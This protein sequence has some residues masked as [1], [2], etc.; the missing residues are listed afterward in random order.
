MLKD[1]REWDDKTGLAGDLRIGEELNVI[2]E[3]VGEAMHDLVEHV[4][5]V[6]VENT[7]TDEWHNSLVERV[8][9]LESRHDNELIAVR[10]VVSQLTDKVAL[11]E[12]RDHAPL[13]DINRG[14][15]TF[16]LHAISEVVRDHVSKDSTIFLCWYDAESRTLEFTFDGTPAGGPKRM[17]A[18]SF[19][20][21]GV[22]AAIKDTLTTHG[23]ID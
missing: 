11:I 20:T 19:T 22:I 6:S 12:S 21:D 1:A 14:Q 2:A 8:S 10:H 18:K 16:D 15:G 7:L 4:G 5:R 3:R 17:Y 23:C 13:D 9:A